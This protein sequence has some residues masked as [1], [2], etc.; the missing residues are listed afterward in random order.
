MTNFELVQ[1]LHLVPAA[2]ATII[3]IPSFGNVVSDGV[4]KKFGWS[5][6]V[7]YERLCAVNCILNV[8][9]LA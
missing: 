1:I 4:Q 3:R 9:F 6:G 5:V 8:R 7:D 2:E